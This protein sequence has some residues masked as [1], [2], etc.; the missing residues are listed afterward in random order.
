MALLSTGTAPSAGVEKNS[1]SYHLEEKC[2]PQEHELFE[3]DCPLE[4]YCDGTLPAAEPSDSRTDAATTTV[5]LEEG[6]NLLDQV[7]C[8]VLLDA[9]GGRGGSYS[10]PSPPLSDCSSDSGVLGSIQSTEETF[11]AGLFGSDFIQN[12]QFDAYSPTP[13]P[14]ESSTSIFSQTVPAP[15]EHQAPRSKCEKENSAKAD[16]AVL[17][18]NRKNAEAARQNRIKKKKYVEGLEKERS[19]LKTENVV[20]KTKCHEYQTRCQRLQSE[21]D[22][23]KSVLANESVLAS[24]I[25]NIPSVPGVKLTSSFRKRANSSSSSSSAEGGVV[26][27]KVKLTSSAG[28]CLH[29]SKNIVSLEFCENCSKQASTL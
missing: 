5:S 6:L 25:Q 13:S 14:S 1:P 18:K 15:D 9:G 28:V 20:L 4:L 16:T 8:D 23:L 17:D 27:K 12:S 10:V 22:Y 11:L 2:C 19:S 3:Y 29:V 7:H 26:T 21:V 24:L